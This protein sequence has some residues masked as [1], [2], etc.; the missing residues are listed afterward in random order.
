MRIL[1]I[2]RY[3]ASRKGRPGTRSYEFGRHRAGRGHEVTIITS[4]LANAEFPVC[5]NVAIYTEAGIEDD[6]RLGSSASHARRNR[7]TKRT[8]RP[9]GVRRAH[10]A[11]AADTSDVS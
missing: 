3:F 1:Y 10:R 8:A 5:P 4:G 2:H 9:L 7:S 11:W 6:V